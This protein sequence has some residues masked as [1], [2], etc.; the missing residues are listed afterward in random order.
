MSNCTEI[1]FLN[2]SNE[3]LNRLNGTEPV[4]DLPSDFSVRLS[5]DVERLTVLGKIE[6]EGAL[7]FSA[8]FTDVNDA[9]FID[10][11]SPNTLDNRVSSYNVTAFVSGPAINFTRLIVKGRNYQNSTWELELRRP[12]DHWVELAGQKKI[13]ELDYGIN[14]LDYTNIEAIWDIPAYAG[15]YDPTENNCVYWPV[16]DYGGWVDQTE[17]AQGSETRVKYIGP[18]DLRPHISLPYILKVGFCAIGWTID[19]VIFDSEWLRRLWVYALKPTYYDADSRG[20]RIRGRSFTER[21]FSNQSQFRV[22]RFFE[23]IK[24]TMTELL[25]NNYGLVTARTCGIQN[26]SILSLKY[27]FILK[28]EFFNDRLLPFTAIFE[29][30]EIDESDNNVYTGEIISTPDQSVTVEFAAGE[31]KSVSI[32]IETVLKG[33]QKGAIGIN[34]LPSSGFKVLSGLYFEV[35]PTNNCMMT[36]GGF[37]NVVDCVSDETSV[38]DWA[39]AVVHLCNGR[40]ET[41]NDTKTVTIHPEKRADVFGD[42]VPGFLLEEEAPVDISDK[43]IVNSIQVKPIRPDLKRYTRL[44]FAN[45]TDAYIDSLNLTEP[46]HSRK[47]ANGDDLPNEVSEVPNPI[48]EPTYEAVIDGLIASDA[49]GREPLPYLP[50]MWDNTN[51]ERSFNIAPRILFAFGLVR[52]LNPDPKT[53]TNFPYTGFYWANPDNILL[54]APSIN[55]FGYATQLRTLELDPTPTVD[56]NIVFSGASSDL[57]TTFYLGI[58]Q[59]GKYGSTVDL[60][61]MMRMADYSAYDFR[62]LFKFDING[63]SIRAKM[64]GIRDFAP[65]LEIPTPATFIIEPAETECC[66]LPCG[67][68]FTRCEYYQDFGI[69]LRAATLADMRLASFVVDG[70]ELVPTPLTFGELE[71]IDVGGDPYVTNLVDLLNSVGAPYFTFAISTTIHPDR[72]RRYFTIKRP[73]CTPFRILI[74]HT[75][76]D[77]YLYTHEEQKQK[78]FSGSWSALGYGATTHTI[79]EDCVTTTEY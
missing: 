53:N 56:G 40:I 64:S 36:T 39:K 22:L 44:Q 61:M 7:G 32:E 59:Q 68:Q 55:Y 14:I 37:F 66:E 75:G 38:L 8:P 26:Q 79:P 17:K 20:G 19:G 10:Y 16:V 9:L 18:E 21:E 31:T 45:S 72:G 13:N 63:R 62:N 54:D 60:L 74:T 50:R 77:A 57:F 76:L 65:C 2:L 41:D 12:S 52:Q 78:W 69:Y 30:L 24:G 48:I 35:V 43:I 67:C 49:G 42:V 23:T 29:I 4:L 46:A 28:A 3:A 58:T 34:V 73:A 71:I 1:R 11:A 51:G 25:Y 70:I 33:G 6:T 27:K 47:L 15:A 5:K